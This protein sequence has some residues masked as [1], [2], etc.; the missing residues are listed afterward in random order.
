VTVEVP[1]FSDEGSILDSA[2][3][4]AVAEFVVS[5]CVVLSAS[6]YSSASDLFLPTPKLN[7]PRVGRSV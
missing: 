5:T 1:T 7:S 2:E 6:S 3:L 4:A